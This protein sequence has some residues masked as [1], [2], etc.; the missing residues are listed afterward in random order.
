MSELFCPQC[1]RR[2][3][4]GLEVCPDDGTQLYSLDT[5]EVVDPLIGALIDGRFLVKS[6]LGRGG[7][8]AVYRGI[9]TSVNR[10]VAIKVLRPELTGREEALERF[11]REAKLV[12]ELTHPNI[13]RLFEFGQDRERDLLYL[14]MEL[15]RGQ[16]L[17]DLLEQGRFQLNMALEVVYQVCG[18]LT[19]P[20]AKGVIHRDLKPDN[21]VLL[22]VSDGT[23]QV[24]VLDF[25]IARTLERETQLTKT[26]MICGTPAYMAPE[27]AQNFEIDSRTDLYALG[28][29]LFE[30]LSGR[31]PF[32]G[33]TSLQILL[34]H[35]QRPAPPVSEVLPP[36]QIPSG[37]E[38][39]VAS[40][41]AKR[42]EDRPSS[43]RAVREEIEEIRVGLG[44]RPI[45]LKEEN[46]FDAFSLPR[47]VKSAASSQ[48]ESLLG[49]DFSPETG[50]TA[51]SR[52]AD[53]P[54]QDTE[55]MHS[56]AMGDVLPETKV[57]VNQ[58]LSNETGSQ[59]R[60]FQHV[61]S[62][63]MKEKTSGRVT[64][65]IT[66]VLS[67]PVLADRVS[68]EDRP[69]VGGPPQDKNSRDVGETK[70]SLGVG[71]KKGLP[72]PALLGGGVL[73]AAL[74]VIVLFS[75]TSGKENGS[76]LEASTG[77]QEANLLVDRVDQD[78]ESMEKSLDEESLGE[79]SPDEQSPDEESESHGI[80]EGATGEEEPSGLQDEPAAP[81]APSE[82]E[83][84][85][86]PEERAAPASPPAEERPR[87]QETAQEEPSEQT[88]ESTEERES[89]ID[90]ARRLR[91]EED[92][93]P[94]DR[95]R[96]LR[97]R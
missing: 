95:A 3:A 70:T 33:D 47:L 41:L 63:E 5:K 38:A 93:S 72:L 14:V 71:A 17:G 90:R 61:D 12:S 7:M 77:D 67:G 40:L 60:P 94:M 39:L 79:E 83:A 28:V 59:T 24:K 53:T 85:R 6:L 97:N 21:I 36:G 84:A 87:T 62:E 75:L 29:L 74:L 82:R 22:P 76:D 48:V 37:V 16:P 30:M 11:F 50:E 92:S 34:H 46:S 13:V 45:R 54:L 80:A 66:E 73:I 58:G 49:M 96:R 55:V 64:E 42:Q 25:G 31:P 26:G 57:P 91:E 86:S 18:A 10:E 51:N 35:I 4:E 69:T 8:G 89:A 27:Q 9:Q 44:L 56:E 19:E 20:H 65:K 32:L 68:Q 43:A 23:L 1:K 2:F 78:G 52:F 88:G 15:I 81:V